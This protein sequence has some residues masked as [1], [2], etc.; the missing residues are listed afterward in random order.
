MV[1]HPN[2]SRRGRPIASPDGRARVTLTVR[3][4]AAVM[5]ALPPAG[6][7]RSEAVNAILR[8]AILIT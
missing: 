6:E 7:G 4:D 3:I 5:D 1:N 8:A 2:R